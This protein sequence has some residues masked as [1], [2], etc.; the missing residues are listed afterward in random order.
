MTH[1]GGYSSAYVPYCG[2]AVLEALSGAN[3]GIEDPFVKHI[4]SYG[5]QPL[6]PNQRQLI[7]EVKELHKHS[8]H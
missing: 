2:L 6:Q 1:E 5:G 7:N 8:S 3:S 4:K